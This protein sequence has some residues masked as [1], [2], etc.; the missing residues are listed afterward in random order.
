MERYVQS[1]EDQLLKAV[2]EED[3]S[4]QETATSFKA[5]RRAENTQERKEKPLYGQFA[6]ETE[7]QSDEDTWT[8]LKQG[9]LKRETEAPIIA[10]QDQ[11]IRTNYIK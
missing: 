3:S 6:R 9:S 11:E 8:W 4:S 2:R 10:A 1:S 7:D 5:R